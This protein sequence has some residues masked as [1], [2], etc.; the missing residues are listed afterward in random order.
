MTKMSRSSRMK[1]NDMNMEMF[2]SISLQN[3]L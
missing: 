3:P 2:S 1:D